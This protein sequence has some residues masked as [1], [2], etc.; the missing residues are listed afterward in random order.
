MRIYRVEDEVRLTLARRLRDW[1]KG[2]LV[3][4][5][6]ATALG[7]DL[8]TPLRRTGLMLRLGLAGF[9]VIAG[10]AT[11]GLALLTTNLRSELAAAIT[12]MVLGVAALA[13]ADWIARNARLY[14]YGVEEALAMGGVALL[15]LGAGLLGA[16]VSSASSDQGPWLLATG[17]LA[18]ACGV[19]YRRFGF[20]YAAVGTLYAIAVMPA[21][22]DAVDEEL[23]RLFAATVCAGVALVVTAR[24]RQVEDDIRQSDLE[25]VRAA[26]VVGAYLALNVFVA[27]EVLGRGV[28]TWFRWTSWALTWLLP[29]VAGRL[30]I[31][32]RDPL[33]LRVAMAAGLASLAT[34]KAYLGWTRQPWD[35]M[36]LGVVLVTLA[37]VLRRW[38]STGPNGE[39]QGFTAARLTAGDDA[40]I[41]LATVAAVAV[42][43]TPVREIPEAKEPPFSGGRSG[44]AGA[45]HTF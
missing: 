36:V 2:G 27:G 21:G 8:E 37:L 31:V 32:D 7:A 12:S 29:V 28:D 39:R 3:S 20:Q 30:A 26:A 22:L 4:A 15:G 33:L 18:A 5:D 11:V 23:T 24:R 14:R 6:Q 34:N 43:P 45:S 35:P 44:G 42:Q 40:T 17:A 19:V 13:G 38:L 41:Q 1:A 10:A 25:V 16:A 9:T